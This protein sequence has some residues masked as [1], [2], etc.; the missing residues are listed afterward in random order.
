[1]TACVY[2][3]AKKEMKKIVFI[4]VLLVFQIKLN[5]QTVPV[6]PI[7]TNYYRVVTTNAGDLIGKIL[8]QD[9]R[10]V[11]LETKDLRKLYIPQYTIKAIV[12][13][14]ANDFN[15][16]GVYVGEDKF[17]TRY[18]LTTNGLPIKKGEHYIQWNFFGPDLQFGL[19]NNLGVG[20]MTTWIGSPI[21]ASFKKSFE[22]G[23]RAQL[24]IGGL[25]GT[26]SWLAPT[27]FGVLPFGSLSFGDRKR[28]IAFS[29]GYGAFSLEGDV[30]G[31]PMTSVAGMAKISSK[32]SFVFDSFILLPSGQ[33]D[34]YGYY[35]PLVA[36]V[37]PGLRW[38]QSEGKAVQFGFG[39]AIV[40][41]ELFPLPMIQWYRSF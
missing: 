15:A 2:F 3:W 16:K 35:Q 39:G 1:M 13:I 14:N 19:G 29:G 7:D 36:L 9:E 12:L 27:S 11:L 34:P 38:H 22:L 40:D 6:N 37:V 5:A 20:I 17:A 28:N 23:S 31:R 25:A 33:S 10:E 21:I 32:L 41:G 8:S 24:A 26:G 4:I 18:F 30:S